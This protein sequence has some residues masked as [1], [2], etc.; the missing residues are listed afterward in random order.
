MSRLDSLIDT[1]QQY[2]QQKLD[3]QQPAQA[4][5]YNGRGELVL[6]GDGLFTNELALP[7]T[8]WARQQV[9]GRLKIPYKYLTRC[10]GPL[11]AANLNHWQ[12]RLPAG[13]RWLI[14]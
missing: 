7:L 13:K 10:P 12:G 2:D 14:R 1:A 4:V 11:Q 8:N 3:Q 6:P 5:H 9:C